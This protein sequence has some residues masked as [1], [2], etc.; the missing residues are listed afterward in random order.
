MNDR[1]LAVIPKSETA[2]A[3]AELRFT[4]EQEKMIRDTYANGATASEFAVLMEV[5]KAR[6]LN[7]LLRQVHFVKRFD[8][9]KNC[10]VWAAQVSIDG[11]RAIAERTRMYDGQ[12]E[13][14][15]EYDAKGLIVL[16]RVKIYKKGVS[17][18]F[19][20]VARWSEYVQTNK[21]G[22]PSSFW[23]DMPFTMIAKCAEAL[24]F[25]KGFP[26]DASGLYIPEEMQQSENYRELPI[27][28]QPPRISPH[29]H[30]D[31]EPPPPDDSTEFERLMGLMVGIEGDL[32]A[33]ASWVKA[34]ELRERLGSKAAPAASALTRDMQLA[35]E[36]NLVGL[37]QRKE[38][39]R[40]W[41]RLN[42]QVEKLED[43]FR[44][45]AEFSDPADGD[46]AENFE[47]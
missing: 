47:R 35:R 28:Q 2:L 39:S 24:G 18:P 3:V 8:K 27:E 26:E 36:S 11:L 10:Y 5:A 14:E 41:Q 12:D 19:V 34:A 4:P 9:K 15:Y 13:P 32:Q 6:R 23:N 45:D 42:R 21:D 40:I 30:A 33:C 44:A 22:S 16:A 38:L 17:R 25:R 31:S 20:G 1:A 29:G 43:K 7:P 46:D 37:E